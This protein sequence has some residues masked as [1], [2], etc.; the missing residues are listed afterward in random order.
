MRNTGTYGG[1][2]ENTYYTDTVPTG[3]TLMANTDFHTD[4]S[5][6]GKLKVIFDFPAKSTMDELIKKE[7][8]SIMQSALHEQLHH[9]TS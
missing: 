7:V 9:K 8:N 2:S 4:Y 1:M 6:N 3:V 5:G